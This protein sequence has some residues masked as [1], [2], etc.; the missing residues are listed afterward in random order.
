METL[1]TIAADFEA[2]TQNL[3][4]WADSLRPEQFELRPAPGKW[5]V[6][7]V[8]EHLF[9]VEK[10][11]AKLS[12]PDAEPAERDLEKSRHRMTRGM[13]DLGQPNG[14]RPTSPTVPNFC[15]SVPR[16]VGQGSARLSRT[17]F[18]ATS[19]APNGSSSAASTPIATSRK[20]RHLWGRGD[21]VVFS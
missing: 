4:A 9:I 19:P 20:C 2:N 3:L 16:K 10:G 17:R 14:A 6:L 8:L 12:R 1:K 11:A 7:E 18:L 15:N 13:A 5:S 21:W